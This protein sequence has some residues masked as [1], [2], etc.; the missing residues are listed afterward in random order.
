DGDGFAMVGESIGAY[1]ALAVAG[2]HA[3]TVPDDVDDARL[4]AA[5][6][7]LAKVAFPVP[8]EGDRRARAAVLLVPAIGF[9]M[10][11]GALA[12]VTIPILVRTG[13]RDAICS[14]A[15]VARALRSLGDPARV[16]SLDVP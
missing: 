8:T 12:D 2:G 7:E 4:M 13:G 6:A 10:A 14:A 15:L 3:M 9:F 1:T 11:E 5:D 16:S